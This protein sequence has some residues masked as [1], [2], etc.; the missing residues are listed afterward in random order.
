MS[1]QFTP[2]GR[3]YTD[4]KGNVLPIDV[5]DEDT[6]AYQLV[7][8]CNDYI[9]NKTYLPPGEEKPVSLKLQSLQLSTQLDS[10]LD[11][12]ATTKTIAIT[13]SLRQELD[14]NQKD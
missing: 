3:T 10:L 2:S 6:K 5:S 1:L 7:K 12:T 11:S 13:T 8:E 4:D 9:G 14:R